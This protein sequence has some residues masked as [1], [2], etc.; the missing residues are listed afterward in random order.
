MRFPSTGD[1]RINAE[2][3]AVRAFTQSETAAPVRPPAFTLIELL[4]VIAIIAILAAMLL[5]ALSAAKEK[6]L[7]TSCVNNFKQMG[8]AL[9]F[10][11]ADNNDT[12][13]WPNWGTPGSPPCAPGWLYAN[14]S[15]P[16]NLTIIGVNYDLW[17][18]G[19]VEVLKTGSYWQ[20]APAANAY[21]CP[22]DARAV[23]TPLWRKRSQKLSSYVMNGAS[24]YYPPMTQWDKYTYR[25]CKMTDIWSADCY[26]QWEADPNNVSTYND[27]GN[28]PNQTEGIGM[29]HK[30]GANCLGVDGHATVMKRSDFLRLEMP[31]KLGVGPKNLFHWNP[32]TADGTG[33]TETL[34]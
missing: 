5:P 18:T 8:L 3:N 9:H 28:Y 20:Y 16:V 12:M 2:A 6:A 24:A 17:N 14:L 22:V 29:L 27:G 31:E 11:A 13:P 34:P 25:T 23:G 7:R 21:L 4:V 30:L 10:Y 26:I 1:T 19:R 15:S 32:I 33:E